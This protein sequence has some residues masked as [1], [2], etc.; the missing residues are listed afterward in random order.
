MCHRV[1]CFIRHLLSGSFPMAVR[2]VGKLAA[3]LSLAVAANAQ[4]G[5]FLPSIPKGTI[6]IQLKTLAAGLSAP[7]YAI[8]PPGDPTR[9]FVV[10]QNGLIWVVRNGSLQPTP[11]LNLLNTVSPPLNPNSTSEERGLLG[12]A[13]HPDFITPGAPGFR[14]LYTYESET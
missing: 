12:L 6:S 14:T 13:F 5:A 10:D 2:Y 9:L 1:G 8:A 3:A 11:A 4:A 7:D